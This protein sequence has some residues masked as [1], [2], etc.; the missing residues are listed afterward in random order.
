MLS[1]GIFWDL[2]QILFPLHRFEFLQKSTHR[3]Q[4]AC[5]V[6]VMGRWHSELK[7]NTGMRQKQSDSVLGTRQTISN[8]PPVATNRFYFDRFYFD[9]IQLR[10]DLS[11]RPSVR[12]FREAVGDSVEFYLHFKSFGVPADFY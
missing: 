12:A 6:T 10:R 1:R 11:A 4:N 9:S 3:S 2:N 8:Q 5:D 7:R